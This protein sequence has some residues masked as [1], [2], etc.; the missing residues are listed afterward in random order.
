MQAYAT[1]HHVLIY[2]AKILAPF[3]PFLTE[4]LYQKW[5]RDNGKPCKPGLA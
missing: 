5:C 1:L 3:V 4:E 2:T